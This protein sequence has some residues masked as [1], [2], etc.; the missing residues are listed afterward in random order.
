[1]NS[2]DII[3]LLGLAPLDQE[4]GF[5]KETYRSKAGTAIY[6]L[7]T[8]E[9][10]SKKHRIKYDEVFHFYKGDAVMMEQTDAEGVITYHRLGKNLRTGELPQV[11]VP[12][13][14]WQETRLVKGGR[15][16]L[17]GTTVC[18]PFEFK[19]FELA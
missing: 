15:W 18:P 16:A 1:M 12:G 13:G 3:E 4:G 14:V 5:F 6:Y 17:L 7:I 8:E 10:Y 19:D 2:N 9:S 11:V